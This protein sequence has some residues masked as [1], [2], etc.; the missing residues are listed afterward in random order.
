MTPTARP[1]LRDRFLTWYRSNRRVATAAIVTGAVALVAVAFGL[2]YALARDV[3]NPV[4]GDPSAAPTGSPVASPTPSAEAPSPSADPSGE[5]TP[6]PSDA[7][8]L[9]YDLADYAPLPGSW[10]VVTVDRLNVRETNEEDSPVVGQLNQGDLVLAIDGGGRIQIVAEGISGWVNVADGDDLWIRAVLKPWTRMALDGIATDGTGYLA[11]GTW[12]NLDT[13]PYEGGFE[14]PLFLYSPDGETWTESHDG[15]AGWVTAA[16]GNE[17][18]WVVISRHGYGGSLVTFS[19][20]GRTFGE[21]QGILGLQ[22]AVAHG[23]AGWLIVGYDSDRGYFSI[24][25]ADG[26]TWDEPITLGG[27]FA[28]PRIEASS[29]GYITFDS[30]RS[31]VMTTTNGVDWNALDTPGEDLDRVADVELIGQEL[32]VLVVDEDGNSTIHRGTFGTNGLITWGAS[33]D[34]SAFAGYQLDSI[35]AGDDGW[36]ALGWDVEALV[37]A[38]WTSA[39]GQTWTR[40][41]HRRR[42]RREHRPGARVRCR[43]LRR[44]RRRRGRPVRAG[45]PRTARRG[46]WPVPRSRSRSATFAAPMPPTSRCSTSCSS[47]IAPWSATATSRSPSAAGCPHRGARGLLHPDRRPAWLAG[48][49]PDGWIV[50]GETDR[51]SFELYVSPDVDASGIH[52]DHTWVEVTGHFADAAAAGCTHT[53]IPQLVQRLTSQEVVRQECAARFVVESA[54]TVD[55]P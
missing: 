52:D 41:G 44:P 35:S 55:A 25:S 54:V 47:A 29:V 48:P 39:D 13:T 15:V 26:V 2:A 33:T 37:P 24:R 19:A 27:D 28:A 49:Y 51:M 21:S 31:G 5:P 11:F 8:D 6:A 46:A 45:G 22:H 43:R 16:D 36:L 42:L 23:P 50:P 7:P 53:P 3:A 1:S 14:A 17:D 18:G 32:R 9:G 38:A 12:A 30:Q 40:A 10:G 4:A 34:A 20:D